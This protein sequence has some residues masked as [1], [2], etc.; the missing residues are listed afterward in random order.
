[1]NNDR[2][3][4]LCSVT[5]AVVTIIA[6][7]LAYVQTDA[8]HLDDRANRDSKRYALKAF[9]LK[10]RGHS[11]AKF[12]YHEAYKTQYELNRLAYHAGEMDQDVTADIFEE[13]AVELTRHSNLFKDYSDP[14]T[15]EVNVER[16]EA[17]LYVRDVARL[18]QEFKAASDVKA[19]WDTKATT[20]IVHL[21]LLAVSLFLLG[22]AS[23]LKRDFTRKTLYA[24]GVSLTVVTLFWAFS[25]WVV[26][27]PDL[28][29]TG[30][31]K[32]YAEGQALD[33]QGLHKEAIAEYDQA[34][35][36]APN[37]L[38][39]YIARGL[40]YLELQKFSEAA[41]NFEAALK[42]NPHD[43]RVTA[44]LSEAYY[45][46]GIFDKSI[47]FG[48]QAVKLSPKAL[49]Y[50]GMLSLATMGSGD[51]DAAKAEYKKGMEL[52]IKTVAG[53]YERGEQ[54]P[55]FIWETLDVMSVD[56]DDLS[57]AA[58]SGEGTPPKDKIQNQEAVMAAC[59]ELRADI[60]GLSVSLEYTGKPPK[61]KLTAEVDELIFGLPE[62]DDEGELQNETQGY[63]DD[64]FPAGTGEV[65]V[66][67]T[68]GK[69]ANGQD[70]VMRVFLEG[71]ELPSWRMLEK[72]TYGDGDGET[73]SWYKVLS[74]GY[75]ESAEL[76]P[77][78]YTV[79][80]FFNGHL[81]LR[82]YFTIA[83]EEEE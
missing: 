13:A 29:T 65:V 69:V 48:K 41:A 60:D 35:K 81:A 14:D 3:N 66:E 61:E 70:L 62:Y 43:A 67:F 30:A 78:D 76:D 45:E 8:G 33:Y 57:D 15:G 2:F 52:A 7:L 10:V 12:A 71:A 55:S 47:K 6:A 27:V 75:S 36:A 73:D 46:Q 19:A 63:P 58:E 44:N 83:G 56:L 16:F 38:D 80:F 21:T 59:L 54:P 5:I 4:Q 32:Y 42:I 82:D 79:E 40:G 17:D 50:Q 39:G 31:I 28:R 64:I 11:E 37:Y 24:T 34:I 26:A 23:S 22:Q 49:D 74:P 72:W 53:A 77:G 9:G 18:E 68:H 51:V 20:Y 25:I 1:M